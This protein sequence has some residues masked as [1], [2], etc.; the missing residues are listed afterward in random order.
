MREQMGRLMAGAA[1]AVV[2]AGVVSQSQ[3]TEAATATA[4]VSI[5]ASVAA[6][7]LVSAA[8]INFGT[9]DPLDANDSAP[10]DGSGTFTVR[11][12]RGVT[13]EVGLDDGLNYSG[14]RRMDDGGTSYLAYELYS[15]SGRSTV[16]DNS[17]N[18][19]SYTAPNKSAYTMTIYGR[20]PGNQDPAAGS[21]GDTV[22]V[23]AEF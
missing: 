23:V 14:G 18:R 21:Y 20:V 5:S 13:A 22:Q 17:A 11:C 3:R 6:N 15:D 16:W 12:T 19:V 10:L 2:V 8:S 9:Y 7:C 1:V 4:N